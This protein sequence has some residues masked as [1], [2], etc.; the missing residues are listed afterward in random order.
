MGFSRQEYWN[1]LPFP[2]L[3]DLSNPGIQPTSQALAS[4][5]MTGGFLPLKNGESLLNIDDG[6]YNLASSLKAT[7]MAS[8]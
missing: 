6:S 7:S 3:G 4:P 5:V 2:H 1:G 8:W